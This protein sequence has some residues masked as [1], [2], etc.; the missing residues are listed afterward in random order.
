[1]DLSSTFLPFIY[2]VFVIDG[3]DKKR[4]INTSTYEASLHKCTCYSHTESWNM[5]CF[6]CTCCGTLNMSSSQENCGQRTHVAH[7]FTVLRP[8]FKDRVRGG[9]RLW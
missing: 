2:W 7:Y 8:G 1:M 3:I 5:L 6:H 9:F 4:S